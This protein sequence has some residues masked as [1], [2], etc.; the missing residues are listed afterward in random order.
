MVDARG[1]LFLGSTA[2]ADAEMKSVL[3]RNVKIQE[4]GMV[5]IQADKNAPF[6]KIVDVLVAQKGAEIPQVGFVTDPDMK[7]LREGEL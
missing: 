7:R 3:T 1:K 5:F 4:D 2:I 6:S